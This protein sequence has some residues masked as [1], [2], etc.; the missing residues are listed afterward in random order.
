MP[1]CRRASH[2]SDLRDTVT[3]AYRGRSID[4]PACTSPRYGATRPWLS[5]RCA[6][7]ALLRFDAETSMRRPRFRPSPT[8]KRVDLIRSCPPRASL[9]PNPSMLS[10]RRLSVD[11][12]D[13]I[14]AHFSQ[15]EIRGKARL[16]S[17]RNSEEINTDPIIHPV[18]LSVIFTRDDATITRECTALGLSNGT[19]S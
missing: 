2:A 17:N 5:T 3:A 4:I 8:A 14:I 11:L 15:L 9:L 16:T 19:P 1:P 13:V 18:N 6:P 10:H 7:K 12:N